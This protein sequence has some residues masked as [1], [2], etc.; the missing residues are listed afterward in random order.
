MSVWCLHVRVSIQI[1]FPGHNFD[2]HGAISFIFGIDIM[3]NIEN[4]LELPSIKTK[5]NKQYN[6]NHRKKDICSK[7]T[8]LQMLSSSLNLLANKSMPQ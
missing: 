8:S 7:W 3:D 5:Q 4:Q 6:Q 2:M 1:S